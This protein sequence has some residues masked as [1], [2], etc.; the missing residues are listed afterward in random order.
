MDSVA[1]LVAI[2]VANSTSCQKLVTPGVSFPIVGLP[3]NV[4]FPGNQLLYPDGSVLLALNQTLPNGVKITGLQLQVNKELSPGTAYQANFV[5]VGTI[6]TGIALGGSVLTRTIPVGLT[7]TWAIPG[8]SVNVTG[9]GSAAAISCAPPYQL[10]GSALSL[11][12]FC[13]SPPQG[14]DTVPDGITNCFAGNAHMCDWQEWGIACTTLGAAIGMPAIEWTS[15]FST[16]DNGHGGGKNGMVMGVGACFNY[17][18]SGQNMYAPSYP[19]RCC[20]R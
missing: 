6:P 5:V 12:S 10:V 15:S 4:S 1:S 2:S 19:Y 8:I 14:P 3:V 18:N 17:A 11:E 7:T 20:H 16:Y 9:C 13:I